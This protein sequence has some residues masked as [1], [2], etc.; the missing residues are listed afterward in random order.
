M[1][2]TK[3]KLNK[4]KKRNKHLVKKS[5]KKKRTVNK[6][7]RNAFRA[8]AVLLLGHNRLP[9]LTD[10]LK[11]P[12]KKQQK[13]Q[14]N[15]AIKSLELEQSKKRAI[16]N[17]IDQME[18]IQ[19]SILYDKHALLT[20]ELNNLIT[21]LQLYTNKDN[22]TN[23]KYKTIILNKIKQIKNEQYETEMLINKFDKQY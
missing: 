22:L 20:R 23:R 3:K 15:K 5:R 2:Y 11:L 14:F 6:K 7:F 12:T 19:L 13:K 17:S 9:A 1:G 21:S 10:E 8:S 16:A 4:Y 18:T